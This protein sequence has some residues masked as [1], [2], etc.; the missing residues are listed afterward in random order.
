MNLRPSTSPNKRAATRGREAR[1][2]FFTGVMFLTRVPA[3]HLADHEP[4]F[5]ARSTA[6]W[7]L[8][9]ALLGA[10]SAAVFAALLWMGMPATFAACGA[11]ATTASLTGCF[12]E[13]A[14]ADVCD[15]FGGYTPQKRLEIMRDSRVGAFGVVGLVLLLGAQLSLLSALSAPQAFY[16]LVAAH[17]LGRWSS[18]LL[19][20]RVPYVA[21][22]ASL[23]KPLA[24]NVP[25]TAF[26]SATFWTLLALW[27]ASRL[28]PWSVPAL[29]GATTGFAALWARFFRVWLGGLS[30]DAL[31]AINMA[32]QLLVLALVFRFVKA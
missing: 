32:T 4:G 18:V 29:I 11:L 20:W 5:L 19:V 14:F 31:G 10:A 8:L 28:W 9:G 23:A 6:I 24:A 13:D 7:P 26:V 30:G 21:D 3:C 22:A 12:H 16:A 25:A 1:R 15:G 17:A 2:V 27:P